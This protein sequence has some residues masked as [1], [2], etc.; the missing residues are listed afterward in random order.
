M[1]RD[2]LTYVRTW[3]RVYVHE[4]M[5]KNNLKN[6]THGFPIS[7]VMGLPSAALRM[8]EVHEG[9]RTNDGIYYCN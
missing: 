6:L 8:L 3:V 1:L 2:V 5:P 4:K 7:M 9:T